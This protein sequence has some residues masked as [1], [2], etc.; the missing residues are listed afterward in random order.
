MSLVRKSLKTF[1]L[2]GVVGALVVSAAAAFGS[3]QDRIKPV[4]EVCMAGD[5]CAAAVAASGGS[6]EARSGEDVYG[7]ACFACHATGAAGAPKLGDTADWTARIDARG[8]DGMYDGAI[9]GFQ[10]MPAMGLCASCTEEEVRA[11]V[12]FILEGSI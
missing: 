9:D 2:V 5:P 11:A 1:S 3:I 10:A 7:T 4:G 12:D 8:V 6:G